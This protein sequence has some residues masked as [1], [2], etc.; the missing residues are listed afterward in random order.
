MLSIHD[1]AHV[2][3]Y[4][5]VATPYSKWAGG[6]DDAAREATLLGGRL[7]REG[8]GNIFVPIVG[9]HQIATA[10]DIDPLS[11]TIWLAHDRPMMEGAFGLLVAALPGWRDSF[12]I[13]QEIEAF[14]DMGKPRYLMDP[15]TLQVQPL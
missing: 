10:C 2:R 9:S 3:G 15:A 12:G 7:M 14:K 13:E 11:H 5:Y 4:W 6:I 1:I 8:V